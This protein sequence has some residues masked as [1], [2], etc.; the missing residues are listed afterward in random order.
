MDEESIIGVYEE[1]GMADDI[2]Q[3][4]QSLQVEEIEANI[5]DVMI[6][7]HTQALYDEIFKVME[8]FGKCESY[9]LRPEATVYTKYKIVAKK[10]KLIATQIAIWY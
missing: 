4:L 7:V 10:V 6:E 8:V 1:K 5:M 9:G 3:I 2:L